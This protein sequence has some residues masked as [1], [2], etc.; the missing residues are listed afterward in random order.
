MWVAPTIPHSI[1]TV[2]DEDGKDDGT[3]VGRIDGVTLGNALGDSEGSR[4][5]AREGAPVPRMQASVSAG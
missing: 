3:L 1:L 2:G 5:G 4:L